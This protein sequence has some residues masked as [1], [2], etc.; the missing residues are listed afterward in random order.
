[1]REKLWALY[2]LQQLDS[3]L[4]AIKHQYAGL[5]RGQAEKAHYESVKAAHK[6]AQTALHTAEGELNDT[7]LEHQ[8]VE[9]KRKQ[10][11]KKLYGGTVSN[12]KELTAMT[13]EVEMLTRNRERLEE[14]ETALLVDLEVHRSRELEARKLLKAAIAAFNLKASA[15]Q[16]L[17]ATYKAQVKTLVTQRNLSAKEI[18]LDLMKR[19]DA[20]R[21]RN[22]GIAIVCLEDGNACSGCKMGLSRDS[23][24]RLH[25]GEWNVLCENC[26]RMLCEKPK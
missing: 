16:E 1:M 18:A 2:E 5:D 9:A 25:L 10:V 26:G 8:G 23:V 14:K 6:E 17:S 4:D 15:A 21:V 12:A 24:Q 11:E 20:L 19:Y 3:A 7:K 22:N 13:A